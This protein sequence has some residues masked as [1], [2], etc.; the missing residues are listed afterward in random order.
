MIFFVPL[1]TMA[2]S[3]GVTKEPLDDIDQKSRS[4]GAQESL[5]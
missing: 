3:Q 5:P 4:I 1:G 2:R